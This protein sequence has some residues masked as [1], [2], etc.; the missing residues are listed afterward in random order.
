MSSQLKI[1]FLQLKAIL[2]PAI[3]I[4]IFIF[5]LNPSAALYL[6]FENGT[7]YGGVTKYTY[8]P[9]IGPTIQALTNSAGEKWIQW[10]INILA[11]NQTDG[12]YRA[13]ISNYYPDKVGKTPCLGNLVAEKPKLCSR[14]KR[15]DK[16]HIHEVEK[17]GKKKDLKTKWVYI[18]TR[19]SLQS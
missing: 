6:G 15:V 16:V 18:Y 5:L 11:R 7:C 9:A 8:A 3:H 2:S 17:Q 13:Y 1:I 4:Y 14:G 10:T 19:L 12:S